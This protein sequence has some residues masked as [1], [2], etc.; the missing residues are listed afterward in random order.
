MYLDNYID[1]LLQRLQQC[2]EL[3]DIKIIK[4]YPY[5]IKP[6]ALDTIVITLSP[7]GIQCD[8]VE[9]GGS[10]F[11]G[12]YDI[13]AHIFVPHKLGSPVATDVV[14]RFLRYGVDWRV[15]GV[16]LTQIDSSDILRCYTAK[17]SLTYYDRFD[18]GDDS[19]E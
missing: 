2:S 10:T 14:S 4:A 1:E 19:N 16:S 17:C 18:F 11:H 12:R 3:N 9:L 8:N 13:D 5:A 15:Q 7:G 6:T